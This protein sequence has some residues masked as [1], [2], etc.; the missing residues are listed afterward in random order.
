MVDDKIHSRSRGPVQNLTRQ[1]LEG[2]A[3]DGGLR[4]GE[5]ER[6]CIIAHGASQFLK[7]RL[8]NQSDGYRVHVCD[9]CG[10]IAAANL[11]KRAF[12]CKRCSNMTQISQVHIPYAC[13]LLFQGIFLFFYY[14]FYPPLPLFFFFFFN[15][16]FFVN[17]Q[18]L[19]MKGKKYNK[20]GKIKI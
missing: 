3:R 10:L 16:F 5:M 15:Y 17:L 2:R 9:E 18:I 7:E 14:Y 4:F 6:Y 13:K 8:F 12:E 1:P 20:I 19:L 11:Q